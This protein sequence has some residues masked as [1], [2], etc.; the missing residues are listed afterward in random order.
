[1]RNRC[2]NQRSDDFPRY[3]GRGIAICKRWDDFESFITDMGT[4]PSS[5]HTLDRMNVNGNYE[6]S[7]C[8]WATQTEQQ[9]NRR[10]NKLDEARAAAIRSALADG[11]SLSA[12][13]DRYGVSKKLINEIKQGRAWKPRLEQPSLF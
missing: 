3:G 13:A 1:M 6:P 12:V 2:L 10:N 9:R 7:N 5:G 11:Q 8:R 4:A